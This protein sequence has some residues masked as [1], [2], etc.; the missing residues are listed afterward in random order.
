[1]DI[2]ELFFIKDA[3]LLGNSN[4]NTAS[5]VSVSASGTG[6]EPND[7]FP[8]STLDDNESAIEDGSMMHNIIPTVRFTA[9]A[10]T[11]S[12]RILD[13]V[14]MLGPS[15]AKLCEI[16]SSSSDK[17]TSSGVNN[18]RSSN[19]SSSSSLASN[20]CICIHRSAVKSC[21][22]ALENL[23]SSV[24]NNPSDDDKN[25]P[26]DARVAAVSLDVVRAVRLIS[27]FVNAYKSV[28][29]RR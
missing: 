12:L 10:A 20:L 3:G 13:G 9:S 4:S 16:S 21:A 19:E 26:V 1:M 23:A 8:T 5:S 7:A 15:L 2:I 28:T 27:P 25:R 18:D 11:A 6:G 29:K 14:R 24:K 22:K 17:R